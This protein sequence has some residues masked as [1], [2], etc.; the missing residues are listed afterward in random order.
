MSIGDININISIFI[1]TV[2]NI[3]DTFCKVIILAPDESIVFEALREIKIFNDETK[4]TN[5]NIRNILTLCNFK[6]SIE[7]W[8]KELYS[9]ILIVKNN[10]PEENIIYFVNNI[11]E[12]QSK[13]VYK[14]YNYYYDDENKRKIYI[15][16]KN[17]IPYISV[18][19]NDYLNSINIPFSLSDIMDDYNKLKK[20]NE[21]LKKKIKMK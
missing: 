5:F 6:G 10:I 2:N 17:N 13:F 16:E 11:Y 8:R 14:I 12:I 18:I 9:K 1:V 21:I 4:N 19:K 7:D 3:A 20:E 15:Y